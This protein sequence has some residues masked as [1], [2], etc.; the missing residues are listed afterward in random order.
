LLGAPVCSVDRCGESEE[1]EMANRV[2]LG[3]VDTC[4]CLDATAAGASTYLS[5]GFES[6]G[7]MAEFAAF[8]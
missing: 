5:V 8:G 6:A 3:D 1:R 4:A 2:M 7:P